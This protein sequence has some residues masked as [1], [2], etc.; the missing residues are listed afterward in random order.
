[1]ES[2]SSL[3]QDHLATLQQRTREILQRPRLDGLLIHA[4]EPIGR[5]LN[6]HDYPFK[7]NPQFKA[8]LPVTRVPHCWVR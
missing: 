1:M 5:F 6:D 8:W 2:L 3:Y 7:V 4:G